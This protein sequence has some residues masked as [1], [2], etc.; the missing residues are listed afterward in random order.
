MINNILVEEFASLFLTVDRVGPFQERMEEFDF[1]DV[2]GDPCNLYLMVSQNGRGKTTI[3]ELLA[4]M[5]G[6]LGK[7]E[8]SGLGFEAFDKEGGRAQWDVRVTLNQ[9]GYKETTILSLVAGFMGEEISLKLWDESAL[10][11]YGASC[12][13]R[14]GFVRNSFGRY[15][16]VGRHDNWVMDFNALIQTNI[17]A[18]L[19][20][21]E[22]NDLA[23]P[24]LIYFSAYRNIISLPIEPR[25]IIA[26]RDW[27]YQPVHIFNVEG[28]EWQD[29]LDNLLV[30]MKWLDDGRF[31]D[32]VNVINDR[33]FKVN[34]R[35][36]FY[37]KKLKGI[38][39]EP[40]EAIIEVEGQEHRLDRL[41]SGE[42]SLIQL[43]LRL[44]THMTRNTILLVDEPE[45]HLHRNWQYETLYSLMELSK[46]YFPG[47]SVVMATHSERIMKAF[48]LNITENNLRKGAYIIETAD[49]EKR[50]IKITE[51]A[52]V[53]KN[54]ADEKPGEDES[55]QWAQSN[56]TRI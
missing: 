26:P 24:T 42:K 33:V 44:G 31:E 54:A 48:G 40:P 34:D 4:A 37:G 5:M 10:Q 18:R 46:K 50:S 41:S 47:F 36:L 15:N 55:S 23:F 19:S 13:H 45:V 1:T 32:A 49:E 8:C 17:G 38:R 28:Q 35:Q 2:N 20:G 21:F 43:F 12:W 11:K 30:W 7:E 6:M 29:S 3:M 53:Q 22:S 51:D 14:F 52:I 9:G 39:K 25:A 27:N 16:M 56:Q